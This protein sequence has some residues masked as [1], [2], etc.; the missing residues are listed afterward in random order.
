MDTDEIIEL[1]NETTK[2]Y[3]GT[4][5]QLEKD[6][7]WPRKIKYVRWNDEYPTVY[8]TNNRSNAIRYETVSSEEVVSTL[9]SM[10]DV[11]NTINLDN[12][13]IAGGI[14]SSI[15]QFLSRG[16][17]FN[18]SD[19]GDIDLFFYGINKHEAMAKAID[20][21]TCVKKYYPTVSL[22]RT[23]CSLT[24]FAPEKN[25]KMQIILR[26]H[27]TP[28]QIIHGFDVG[29]SMVG[30]QNKKLFTCALGIF[31][32]ERRINL[33]LPQY[34]SSTYEIRL[35]KYNE[36]GYRIVFPKLKLD[37]IEYVPGISIEFPH[38]G[39][40]TIVLE[41][42]KIK[43]KTVFA[44]CVGVF[45]PRQNYDIPHVD[46]KWVLEHHF[47]L[48]SIYRRYHDRKDNYFQYS[49]L[50][51]SEKWTTGLEAI[52]QSMQYNPVDFTSLNKDDGKSLEV[53]Y[54][55]GY[56]KF[57]MIIWREDSPCTHLSGAFYPRLIDEKTWYGKYY[58]DN[59][60]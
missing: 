10:Y 19:L 28:A 9:F 20:L 49:V 52:T 55:N 59:K 23:E 5:S 53:S 32:L 29:P 6:I 58:L 56:R 51:P 43:V 26:L 22:I 34:G 54:N 14:F 33:V 45:D 4:N 16:V 40:N 17:A 50:V 13:I 11:L 47:S 41:G 31:C 24:L 15:I 21:I 57:C 25:F 12:V 39:F 48:S 18:Q 35:I 46:N 7:I 30:I 3:N 42:N 44:L 36:R 38:M 8:K 37:A 27:K 2:L 1:H 60:Q